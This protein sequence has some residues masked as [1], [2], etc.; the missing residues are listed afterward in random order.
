MIPSSSS[1]VF[2]KFSASFSPLFYFYCRTDICFVLVD[3]AASKPYEV[4]EAIDMLDSGNFR[5]I[6]RKNDYN[7]VDRG[8]SIIVL[9]LVRATHYE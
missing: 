9:V 1:P 8:V 4:N 2:S 6:L 5:N 7:M 3:N